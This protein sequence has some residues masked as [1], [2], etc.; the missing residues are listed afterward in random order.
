MKW[1]GSNDDKYT[2]ERKLH[3]LSWSGTEPDE[4]I[5][6]QADILSYVNSLTEELETRK[7]A[8]LR[9]YQCS[10][11]GFT[12]QATDLAICNK[13]AEKLAE[14]RDKLKATAADKERACVH[15]QC[16]RGKMEERLDIANDKIEDL[17]A[18]NESLL[19]TKSAWSES[20]FN[21]YRKAEAYN[22]GFEDCPTCK[23]QGIVPCD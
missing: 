3:A 6:L 17:K 14:E 2:L 8:G 10:E 15:L 7:K 9:F 13:C 11:C 16:E 18:E 22:C 23:G 20:A 21:N 19:L 1:Y 4:V 12:H 5:A